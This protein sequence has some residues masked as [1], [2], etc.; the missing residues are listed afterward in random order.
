M[1]SSKE[2]TNG[3]TSMQQLFVAEYL[4]DLNATQAAL[5]AGASPRSAYEMGSR[6]L[7]KVEVR[8]AIAIGIAGRIART[9][10]T[11]DLIVK[12]LAKIAFAD[13]TE[14]MAIR[15]TCCR[16]C[17]GGPEFLYTETPAERRVRQRKHDHAMALAEQGR[18]AAPDWDSTILVGFRRTADP[19]PECPEC[20]GDGLVSLLLSDTRFVSPEARALFAG[21]Q[22]TR[23][24][25]KVSVH[26]K[27]RALEM[28]GQHF[29][30]FDQ[31]GNANAE[32]SVPVAE[33]DAIYENALAEVAA[34]EAAVRSRRIQ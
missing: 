22:I 2:S 11:A 34:S 31:K 30:L 9:E 7:K 5:R 25:I 28:L 32:A 8:D 24:G 12:E 1:S 16:Y 4:V 14:L 26:D 10:V 15:R 33:L 13:A 27:L 21:A 19:N 29:G 3:L 6:W 23:H 18:G 17:W 20:C